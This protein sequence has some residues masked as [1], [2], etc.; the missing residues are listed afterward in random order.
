MTI[1]NH[2]LFNENI[3]SPRQWTEEEEKTLFHEM[4]AHE[5]K[6]THDEDIP[7]SQDVN[8]EDVISQQEEQLNDQDIEAPTQVKKVTRT[9]KCYFNAMTQHTFL[10]GSLDVLIE[11]QYVFVAD[12][13][14]LKVK[15]ALKSPEASIWQ[16]SIDN[17]IESLHV[18]KVFSEPIKLSQLPHDTNITDFKWLLKIKRTGLHKS[19]IVCRGFTHKSMELITRRHSP[20]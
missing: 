12:T 11:Y 5:E 17:E 19:R 14:T 18:N 9:G 6:N 2:V 16:Q 13:N 20:Q 8:T 7:L 3:A 4:Y 10:S 15:Q 1:T